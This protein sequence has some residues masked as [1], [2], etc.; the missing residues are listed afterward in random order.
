MLRW[1]RAALH[2]AQAVVVAEVLGLHLHRQCELVALVA[3]SARA[4]PPAH[5]GEVAAGHVTV[6]NMRH[7]AAI[8]CLPQY[9]TGCRNEHPADDRPLA[10]TLQPEPSLR[11][12]MT[13]R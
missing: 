4:P 11:R 2:A 12:M 7:Y 9:N 10:T 8:A 6:N 3:R 1:F 13:A 5:T